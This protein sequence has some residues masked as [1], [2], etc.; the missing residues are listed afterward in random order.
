MSNALRKLQR[1]VIIN[2]CYQRD[3]HKRAFNDEWERIHY[4]KT[5]EVDEDGK[6]V[7]VKLTKKK[8]EKPKQR[9]FDD[10]RSYVKYLKAMK[11]Y[12][13]GVRNK[14]SKANTNAKAKVC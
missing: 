4:G 12:I 10:G 1:G 9:H 5:E 13:D 2:Q 14:Q 8:V 6:V 7:S 11:T 3:G